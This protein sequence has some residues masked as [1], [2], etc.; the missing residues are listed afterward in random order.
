MLGNSQN[1][2]KYGSHYNAVLH[3][4]HSPAGNKNKRK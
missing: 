1:Y 3:S 4:A 2:L